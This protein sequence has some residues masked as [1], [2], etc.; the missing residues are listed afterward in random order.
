MA[1]GGVIGGIYIYEYVGIGIFAKEGFD[2]DFDAAAT[3]GDVGDGDGE[4][5]VAGAGAGDVVPDLLAYVTFFL[6]GFVT[7]LFV[8][9]VDAAGDDA[10]DNFS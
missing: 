8:D 6:D 10:L 7:R 2:V 9:V 1:Y 5:D 3:G 4:F